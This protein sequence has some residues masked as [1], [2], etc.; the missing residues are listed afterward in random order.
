MINS[1]GFYS[2]TSYSTTFSAVLSGVAGK[3]AF[4]VVVV[5]VIA[6]MMASGLFASS[7]K[8]RQS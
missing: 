8:D 1:K 2:S 3:A 6:A 4:Y 7:K 5:F